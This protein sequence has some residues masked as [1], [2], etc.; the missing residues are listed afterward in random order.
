MQERI[1][2]IERKML[3]DGF[4]NDRKK[5]QAL[6]DECNTKKEIKEGYESFVKR[7][8]VM[9][10]DVELLKE[11]FDEDLAALVSEECEAA[12]SE[13]HAYEMKVL[14]SGPYDH[15]NAIIELHPG[16]G[17]TESQDWAEML[18][19]MYSRWAGKKGY[20]VTVLDYLE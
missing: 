15:N 5:A 16:A 19:R 17:G 12:Q 2:D 6:I 20:K 7:M 11:E 13:F 18:Y 10:S 4:W 3:E 1:E 8:E 14:L 9:A